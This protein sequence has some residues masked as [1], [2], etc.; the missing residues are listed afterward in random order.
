MTALVPA[1]QPSS[2]LRPRGTS[3]CAIRSVQTESIR[4]RWATNG[5]LFPR[6]PYLGSL[7]DCWWEGARAGK[8]EATW[9]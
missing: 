5:E 9:K 4:N 6:T 7:H 3:E 2:T 8:V 1:L